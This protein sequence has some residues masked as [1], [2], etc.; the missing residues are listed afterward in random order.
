MSIMFFL[1]LVILIGFFK[2]NAVRA[3]DTYHSTKTCLTPDNVH[4]YCVPMAKCERITWMIESWG[5][6]YPPY[7]VDYIKNS[8]CGITGNIHY[9][10]CAINDLKGFQPTHQVPTHQRTTNYNVPVLPIPRTP[11]HQSTSDYNGPVR[12]PPPPD[13][14]SF[15]NQHHSMNGYQLH[16]NNYYQSSLPVGEQILSSMPCGPFAGHRISN[17]E[18]VRLLEFPWMALLEYAGAKTRK[19]FKCGGTLITNRYVL[20]AAHCVT[21]ASELI[22]VRLG[23]HNLNTQNDCERY[24]KDS[25]DIYCAPIYIDVGIERTIPHPQYTTRPISNDIALIR[26]S[27]A[28]Q[29]QSHIKPICLPRAPYAFNHVPESLTVSGWGVTEQGYAADVLMKANLPLQNNA[30]CHNAFFRSININPNHICAGGVDHRSTCRGDSGGPLF[31]PVNYINNDDI[32]YV[33]FGITSAGEL[34]CGDSS[35]NYP[36]IFT[37]ISNYMDWILT[38]IVL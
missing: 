35:H 3:S 33:Q 27:T 38:N 15:N 4:G 22:S 14:F 26:L 1:E 17:G 37:R 2:Y 10:C 32:R 7:V 9:G 19:R 5:E 36:A 11:T 34:S 16:G 20:T 31:A 30:V 28:V 6:P 8:H 24:F 18:F 23:E 29:F 13:P 12:Y 21:G 25:G